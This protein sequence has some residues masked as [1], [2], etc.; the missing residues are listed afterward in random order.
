MANNRDLVKFYQAL[1]TTSQRQIF[2]SWPI[3]QIGRTIIRI[4]ISLSL[5][6]MELWLSIISASQT[7]LDAMEN[8]DQEYKIIVVRE[9]LRDI[10]DK[11][12]SFIK[13]SSL[14]LFVS[15]KFD[16]L[17]LPTLPAFH[18]KNIKGLLSAFC[19]KLA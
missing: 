10:R 7:I 15:C 19:I 17:A 8:M 5:Q 4:G 14:N 3:F 6:A 1:T 11:V 16:G 18:G 2:G 13:V 12:R 9:K